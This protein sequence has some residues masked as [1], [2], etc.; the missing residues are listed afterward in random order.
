MTVDVSEESR[1]PGTSVEEA[2]KDYYGKVLA[3]SADLKTSACCTNAAPPPHIA[4]ALG[5]VHEEVLDR[6]YG[7][8]SPIP[9]ALEGA[10]VLD[11]GCG[12]GRDAYVLAQLVGPTGRVI[13][14]DMTDEQLAVA[15]RHTDWHAQR[16]GYA[17]VEFRRGYIEDL[18]AAGI[19]THRWTWSSPTVW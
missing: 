16:F 3:S 7:C 17:N 1:A 5:R 18:A 12:S 6:F 8:G 10:T 4:A 11:L 19:G 9:P 15:R 13:G 2:V 14:V